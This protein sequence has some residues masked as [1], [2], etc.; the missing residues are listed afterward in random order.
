[1]GLWSQTNMKPHTCE[2][3]MY[4]RYLMVFMYLS[5]EIVMF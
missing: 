1:M 5:G 3:S 4:T 2:S